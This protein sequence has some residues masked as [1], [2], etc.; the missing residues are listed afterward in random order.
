MA[1]AIVLPGM[2]CDEFSRCGQ[3]AHCSHGLCQCIFANHELAFV[4]GTTQCV[5]TL[6]EEEIPPNTKESEQG[7][8]YICKRSCNPGKIICVQG[9]LFETIYTKKLILQNNFQKTKNPTQSMQKK[10]VTQKDMSQDRSKFWPT[11]KMEKNAVFT[12]TEWH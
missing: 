10:Q 7:Y 2:F 11:E 4:N 1:S 9:P 3:G 8:F 6:E 5:N 12:Q